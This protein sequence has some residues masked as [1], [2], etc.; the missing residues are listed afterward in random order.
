MSD[1]LTQ[2]IILLQALRSLPD[3]VAEIVMALDEEWQ[4][5][6]EVWSGRESVSHL[7][8]CEALFH[9]RFQRILELDNPLLP[10][11]GPDEAPP[12]RDLPIADL[13]IQLREA[14]TTAVL[15]LSA[16]APDTW[17]RPAV[18]ASL[19]PTTLALQVQNMINHDA[20][21]IGQL[22]ALLR[23]WEEHQKEL[24]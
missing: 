12:R 22:M 13:L 9:K 14:R 16:L 19:G 18:H 10:A 3:R 15:F 24:A 1:T 21:H 20:E 5:A 7:A 23:T 6:P 8:A 2:H 4:S 17:K 11:F